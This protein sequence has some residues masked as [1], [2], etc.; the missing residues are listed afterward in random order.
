MPKEYQALEVKEEIVAQALAIGKSQ[1]QAFQLAYPDSALNSSRT[2]STKYLQD[3][4]QVIERAI[5]IVR[6]S[7]KS[8]LR[9]VIKKVEQKLEAQRPYGKDN[10][11][12]DDNSSQL[13]A[14][15]ILLK[16]HGELRDDER[17]ETNNTL[18]I[19][20]DPKELSGILDRLDRITHSE[21]I[22]EAEVI[23]VDYSKEDQVSSSVQ[24]QSSSDKPT[25]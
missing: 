23:S 22:I 25:Q 19:N 14:T 2:H 5:D 11:L 17:G 7:A 10:I 13:E 15:K 6:Q 16:L 9:S 18:V 3:K 20:A 4:P 21:D 24:D 8:N 12:H 1:T